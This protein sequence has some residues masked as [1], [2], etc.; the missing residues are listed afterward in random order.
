MAIHWREQMSVD[1]GVIDEDHRHLIDIINRFD[2]VAA[3]GLSTSEALEILYALKFYT[4]T[5]FQREEYLQSLVD[6]PERDAHKKDHEKLLHTL[7]G[8][9]ER[10]Q[11]HAATA[12]DDSKG[13]L[14]DLL[15]DWLTDHIIGAD[16]RLRPYIDKMKADPNAIG[17]L[18]DIELVR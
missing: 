13:T 17:R 4:T 5:H 10:V 8:I 9:I 2:D 7:V 15:R 14:S 3:D 18:K 16:L 12:H 6:Y 1:H 11:S